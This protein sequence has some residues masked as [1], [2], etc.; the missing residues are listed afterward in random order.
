MILSMSKN[1]AKKKFTCMSFANCQLPY[2]S[3]VLLNSI[4][5]CLEDPIIQQRVKSISFKNNDI[6]NIPTEILNDLKQLV[7]YK[8]HCLRQGA[9]R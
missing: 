2:I 5:E 4:I 7:Y 3:P 8:S 9:S 6:Q 1:M